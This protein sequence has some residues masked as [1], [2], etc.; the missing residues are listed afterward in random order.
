[1]KLFL[2]V[3]FLIYGGMHVY[4]YFRL[5]A[6]FVLSLPAKGTAVV[7]LAF[8]VFCPILIRL[9][10]RQGQEA[11][12]SLLSYVGYLWMGGIFIFVCVACLLELYRSFLRCVGRMGL[13]L[14]APITPSAKAIFL[15]PLV[16]AAVV[17]VYGYIEA[18]QIRTEHLTVRSAKIL[19]HWSGAHCSDS[20]DHLGLIVHV[21][22][23]ENG[24]GRS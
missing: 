22:A 23:V 24:R 15:I 9:L 3:Y 1:M 10:E 5:Q 7:C 13:D 21:N 2:L 20:D 11:A 18:K 4:F 16:V 12:A 14:S 17:N 6:A 19:R 8:L